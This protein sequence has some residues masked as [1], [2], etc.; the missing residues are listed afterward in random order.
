MDKCLFFGGE[1]ISLRVPDRLFDQAI[2]FYC[3]T[4]GLEAQLVDSDTGKVQYG[5]SV[6]W[7]DRCKEVDRCEV[8]L[9]IRTPDTTSAR[10]HL[11]EA[12]VQLFNSEPLPEGY[13]GFWIRS[14]LGNVVLVSAASE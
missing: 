3:K 14:P 6:L 11:Q 1:N 10:T 4:L 7:L 12:G 2:E 9:E 8:R 13:N 5:P